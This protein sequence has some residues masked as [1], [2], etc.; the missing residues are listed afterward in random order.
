[1]GRGSEPQLQVNANLNYLTER[2]RVELDIICCSAHESEPLNEFSC[3]AFARQDGFPYN[4]VLF[5]T[6][7]KVFRGSI[8]LMAEFI[9]C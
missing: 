6:M 9:L 8:I 5:V 3:L 7:E 4:S 2:K 1:M